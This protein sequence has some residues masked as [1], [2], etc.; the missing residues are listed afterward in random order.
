[1]TFDEN[2]GDVITTES[3]P[4]RRKEL[5]FRSYNFIYDNRPGLLEALRTSCFIG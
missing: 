3:S 4:T 5:Q 1:M 2:W